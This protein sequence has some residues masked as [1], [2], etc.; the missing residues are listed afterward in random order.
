LASLLS[1]CSQAG[2][3][4]VKLPYVT[5]ALDTPHSVGL[6]WMSDWPIAETS[7]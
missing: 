1:V 2:E 5:P 3:Q 4:C 7:T 6:L